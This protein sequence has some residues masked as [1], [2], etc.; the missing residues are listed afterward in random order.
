MYQS[1][2]DKKEFKGAICPY[3]YAE[4][5]KPRDGNPLNLQELD[6]I[7]EYLKND[8]IYELVN[9]DRAI[10]LKT[11]ELCRT[12]GVKPTDAIHLACA[13][14]VGCD[15][16]LTWDSKLIQRAMVPG[17]SVEEPRILG[18]TVAII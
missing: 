14:K 6:A 17:L 13:L 16:F 9:V 2:I 7:I 1:K 11:N 8:Q 4:C 3:T 18:Q 12:Y 5:C 15:V 10:G